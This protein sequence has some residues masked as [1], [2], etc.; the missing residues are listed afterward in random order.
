MGGV[1]RVPALLRVAADRGGPQHRGLTSAVYA[2]LMDEDVGE[3]LELP[4]RAARNRSRA[5][6][7]VLPSGA[8]D[9]FSPA[10]D[11]RLSRGDVRGAA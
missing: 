5:G 11:V 1:S 8:R 6:I 4:G 2:H 10:P 7:E 3:A 9:G